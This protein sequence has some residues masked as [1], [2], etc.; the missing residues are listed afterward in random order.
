MNGLIHQ[1]FLYVFAQLHATLLQRHKA[2]ER[3]NILLKDAL[4]E[5]KADRKAIE[6]QLFK[7]KAESEKWAV[8]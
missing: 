5:E 7:S 4:D 6:Q 1:S 3:D 8:K 2:V